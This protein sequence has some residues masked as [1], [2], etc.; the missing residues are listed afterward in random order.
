MGFDVDIPE[1]L[2]EEMRVKLERVKVN[3][4]TRIS[5]LKNGKIDVAVAN[6]SHT[7][8]RDEEIDFS[9]PISGPSRPFS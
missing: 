6:M 9:S 1:A 8:K 3:E 7:A 2:A 5:Y 4:L